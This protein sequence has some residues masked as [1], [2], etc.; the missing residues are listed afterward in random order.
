VHVTE[1]LPALE[2]AQPVPVADTNVTPAGSA[3]VMVRL[4]ASEGPLFVTTSEY[5]TDDPATTL[6]GPALAIARSALAVTVVEALAVLFAGSGSAVVEDTLAVSDSDPAW[7]GAVTVTVMAGALVP[8]V[9]VALVQV[10]ETLPVFEQAQP[11]PVA[12]T[13]VTTAGSVSVTV[14]FAASEGP[15][16]VTVS[17]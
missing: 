6:A 1:T 5:A 11:A 8:A 16:S 9:R 4:A 2:Q 12:D 10:T 14:R 13:K 17:V 7:A 3:S 15:L